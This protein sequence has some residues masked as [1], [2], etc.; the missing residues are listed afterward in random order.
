MDKSEQAFLNGTHPALQRD[1][2]TMETLRSTSPV[3]SSSPAHSRSSSSS[4]AAPRFSAVDPDPPAR[5]PAPLR[6][7]TKQSTNTGVKGV[8][9]D[10]REYQESK[11]SPATVAKQMGK[12]LMISLEDDEDE[13]NRDEDQAALERYRQQRMRELQGSGE[14]GLNSN[15]SERKTFGHLREIGID[16]FL[17]AVEGESDDVAVVIHLYEPDLFPCILLNTHLTALSRKYPHTKFLRALAS[18]LDFMQQDPEDETLPTVLVYRGG[19]LET[20]WIRFDLELGSEGA[21]ESRD[22]RAHVERILL[23]KGA[24]EGAGPDGGYSS[25]RR[26]PLQ[27]GNDGDND[28]DE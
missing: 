21:L 23:E 2:D 12:K 18:E 20:T 17:N 14:R 9:A 8:R 16:Q 1:A 28:D 13:L 4:S 22:A 24:I 10:Y 19:D 3:R 6:N 11:N 5:E 7:N 25:V 27:N 15:G 26:K